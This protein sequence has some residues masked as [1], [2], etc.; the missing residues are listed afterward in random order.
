V[1]RIVQEALTNVLQ[2][3]N[4]T[5]VTVTLRKSS[6]SLTVS[7]ADNGRGISEHDLAKSRSLGLTGMRE[8]SSLVGGRLDV[9]RRP[10]TGTIV[11]LTVP[12]V[13]TRLPRGRAR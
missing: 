13:N 6:S 1:F 5:R 3:A 8:L 10:P 7:V 4:A 12:L 9:R 11:R 2:H